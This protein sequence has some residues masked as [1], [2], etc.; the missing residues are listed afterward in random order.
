MT[1][2]SPAAIAA[3]I[4]PG[5]IIG[6]NMDPNKKNKAAL[7]G[8]SCLCQM[9]NQLAPYGY[10]I[11][12]YRDDN[13]KEIR[14]KEGK[15]LF[16]DGHSRAEFPRAIG[17]DTR[18]CMLYCARCIKIGETDGDT[19]AEVVGS[20]K[21]T[22]VAE[23]D[24]MYMS[25]EVLSLYPH[26]QQCTTPFQNRRNV[27]MDMETPGCGGSGYLKLPFPTNDLLFQQS[28]LHYGDQELDPKSWS[29]SDSMP[30]CPYEGLVKLLHEE[31][32]HGEHGGTKID[33][34][35][36]DFKGDYPYDER[37]Y[38]KLDNSA[39]IS[40][41]CNMDREQY[42]A[43]HNILQLR[44]SLWFANNMNVPTE[45]FGTFPSVEGFNKDPKTTIGNYNSDLFG[46]RNE[47]HLTNVVPTMLFGGKERDWSE[48]ECD[49]V[50]H[51]DF[52]NT[53]DGHSVSENPRLKG[54]GKPGSLII[55]VSKAGRRV[56]I[57][58]KYI[59]V[60]FGQALFFVG[61]CPHAGVSVPAK[62]YV[63]K[64][65]QPALHSYIVS[66]RHQ[67]QIDEF[68]L[69]LDQIALYQPMLFYM[70]APKYAREKCEE[71]G[72][73][74]VTGFDA[75][76]RNPKCDVKQL[77]LL[78]GKVIEE[79]QEIKVEINTKKSDKKKSDKK[80]SDSNQVITRSRKRANPEV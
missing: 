13:L 10:D 34:D 71:L 19:F 60:P 31:G 35:T 22:T 51:K 16:A 26:C 72:D 48:F 1:H 66:T 30:W 68:E 7:S 40:P 45:L 56:W 27:I 53:T 61:D 5:K 21:F 37:Y 74:V 50:I 77:D 47:R 24:R 67:V 44:I 25:A 80:K 49:Q 32:I 76:R 63:D 46:K 64:E 65:C 62:L 58:G 15:E 17:G 75:A 39:N 33:N 28:Q 42:D 43:R 9:N 69:D 41:K 20:V 4:F 38:W 11:Q 59:G 2:Y 36:N 23:G 54:F 70:L 29:Q 79:L 6:E 18:K 3:A 8:Q 57:D 78:L 12:L 52:C 55:P 14:K 73:K